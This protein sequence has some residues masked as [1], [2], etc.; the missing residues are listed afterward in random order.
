MILFKETDKLNTCRD[1][2][3]SQEEKRH[4]SDTGRHGV[5]NRREAEVKCPYFGSTRDVR[6]VNESFFG[7]DSFNELAEQVHKTALNES[8]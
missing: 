8:N 1:Q 4:Q 6:L 7:V 2:C 5:L 3:Q